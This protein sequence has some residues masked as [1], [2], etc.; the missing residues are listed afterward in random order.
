MKRPLFHL[1]IPISC[2]LTCGMMV[3]AIITGIAIFVI[4]KAVGF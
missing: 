2:L 4:L 3:G 1:E